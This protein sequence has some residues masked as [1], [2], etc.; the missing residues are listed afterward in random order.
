MK[1]KLRNGILLIGIL[2]FGPSC[3]IVAWQSEVD[4]VEQRLKKCRY[5]ISVEKIAARRTAEDECDAYKA[6]LEK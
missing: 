2:L 5:L 4:E 6:S 3:G 1:L